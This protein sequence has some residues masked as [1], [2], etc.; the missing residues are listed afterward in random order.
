MKSLQELFE[1]QEEDLLEKPKYKIFCDLDGVLADFDTQF[2]YYT[3]FP[4]GQYKDTYGKKPFWEVINNLGEIYWSAM[5]M[6]PQ[7]KML[8][9]FIR[10]YRPT[11]LSS[12]SS[13]QSSKTGKN[14]WV[15]RNLS[16]TPHIIFAKAE[17]K[18]EYA[19]RNSILIDDREDTI[20]RWNAAGGIGI[21][22][23][24]GNSQQVITQLEQLGYG[25]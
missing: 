23:K 19:D 22:C 16:P 2:E 8:W 18:H 10:P 6:M 13:E 9:N 12:P 4:P 20:G 24:N 11:I 25:K 3:G 1:I 21:L 5:P 17:Q 7:G 15:E 14:I